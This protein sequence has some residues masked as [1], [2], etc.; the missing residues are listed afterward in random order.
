[1]TSIAAFT[2]GAPMNVSLDHVRLFRQLF[3]RAVPAA[4]ALVLIAMAGAWVITLPFTAPGSEIVSHPREAPSLG[5]SNLNPVSVG[6][7]ISAG[8]DLKPDLPAPPVAISE[9]KSARAAI[10]Q[11]LI[12]LGERAPLPPARPIELGA[13]SSPPAP[14]SR[15]TVANAAPG[16]KI[17][18][19]IRGDTF[20]LS[21]HYDR[22][23]AVYD[24]GAHTVYLPNGARLEA[25][26]GL[27]DRLDNPQ[28]V[29][30]INRGATP[31]H[32]Y[33][34]TLREALFHGVQA[35]RLNPVGGGVFGRVGLLAH[36]YMLGPNGDSNGCVSFK[37]YDAFLQAYQ[38]GQVKRLA[39]VASLN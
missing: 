38:T 20:G 21:S 22:L 5:P 11:P 17:L 13:L 16:P 31:P 7:D 25:H 24:L 6:Q 8:I 37:D 28:H 36:S 2:K 30:E 1:M 10:V 15:A 23:T 29:N 26:S 19:S 4:A 18:A 14:V 32:L 3:S 34:L 35:L 39:V 27:G 9:P 33:Q 12:S